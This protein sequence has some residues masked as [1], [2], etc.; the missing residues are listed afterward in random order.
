MDHLFILCSILCKNQKILLQHDSGS[1]PQPATKQMKTSL[2]RTTQW[3]IQCG[4][5]FYSSFHCA[6]SLRR[7][8]NKPDQN[9]ELSVWHACLLVLRSPDPV[10]AESKQISNLWPDIE[11][12]IRYSKVLLL[13]LGLWF[14]DSRL[15]HKGRKNLFFYFKILSHR[16]LDFYS[17][18]ANTRRRVVAYGNTGES[19]SFVV[20]PSKHLNI[21]IHSS[22]QITRRRGKINNWVQRPG[23]RGWDLLMLEIVLLQVDR[24]YAMKNSVK[25]NSAVMKPPHLHPL[26]SK[27]QI[28][29][30]ACSCCF[31]ESIQSCLLKSRLLLELVIKATHFQSKFLRQNRIVNVARQ[32]RLLLIGRFLIKTRY[33]VVDTSLSVRVWLAGLPFVVRLSATQ[34]LNLI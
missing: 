24:C 9:C 15:W 5:R 22:L 11:H 28:S 3:N 32:H 6:R 10:C 30:L 27:H 1:A 18:N 20:H 23:R 19:F 14:I 4:P 17:P 29:D 16:F 13:I 34:F 21:I 31:I 8:S 25:W 12:S 26:R 2:I 7:Q 33:F